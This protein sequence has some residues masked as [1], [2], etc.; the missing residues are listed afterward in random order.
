MAAK[1]AR[2]ERELAELNEL[3]EREP[4]KEPVA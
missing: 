1:I 4:A 2:F 3:A